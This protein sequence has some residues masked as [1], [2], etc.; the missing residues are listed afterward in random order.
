MNKN[1]KY[2]FVIVGAGFAGATCARLLTDKGY[3]CLII[4]ERPFVSGNCVTD[5]QFNI[6]VHFCGAHILHTN[7]NEVWQ[8]LETYGDIHKYEYKFIAWNDGNS[9]PIPFG[10]DLLNKVY[11]KAWPYECE[12]ELIKDIKE[13][14]DPQNLEEYLLSKYGQKIYDLVYKNFYEKIYQEKCVNLSIDCLIE[15]KNYNL[16]YNASFYND[17]Y[18]GVPDK[19][20]VNLVESII[21]DDIDII[22]NKNFLENKKKYFSLG[23]FIIYTGEVD[24]FFNYDSGNMDWI[25]T[26][27]DFKD[28]S[29]KT[30]NLTGAPVVHFTDSKIAWY[31]LTEHKW[32]TPWRTGDKDFDSHTFLTYEF[33]QKWKKGMETCFPVW[34]SR[35]LNLYNRYCERLKRDFPNVLLC[36]R[37]AEFTNY[38]ICETIRSAMDLT[39]KFESII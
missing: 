31:R 28:E 21:G 27:F 30:T 36:G 10:M 20:Y 1:Y 23:R 15:S 4:E 3:K 33:S 29:D 14:N 7:D 5:N 9:Y 16:L 22:L 12:K 19:G 35:S 38:S 24:K 8:F 11:N 6:D 32:L 26:V 2:D 39:N 34:N 18:K 25:S 17:K 13:N 37:K